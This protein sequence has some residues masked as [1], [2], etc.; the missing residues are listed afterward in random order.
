MRKRTLALAL[1]M[2][3]PLSAHAYKL[4]RMVACDLSVRD[5][6]A[7]LVQ[8]QA[9]STPAVRVASDGV[10]IFKKTT[11]DALTF[12]GMTVGLVYGYTDDPLL[13]QRPASTNPPD[14]YGF[15]VQAPIADVQATLSSIGVTQAHVRRIEANV[16][17]IYCEFPP[18]A[19][20]A[21]PQ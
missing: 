15:F 11:N 16:T 4:D 18:S 17:A 7:P 8:A 5:F 3:L 20:P 14:G 9:I 12:Y 2:A 6:F 19:T 10:N 13:F 21:A 1:A